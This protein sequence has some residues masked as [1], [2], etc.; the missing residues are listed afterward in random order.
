ME[1]EQKYSLAYLANSGSISQ[2]EIT[3]GSG[4]YMLSIWHKIQD[5]NNKKF[6]VI[7]H[8]YK[9]MIGRTVEFNFTAKKDKWEQFSSNIQV[10]Q[11]KNINKAVIVIR[12]PYSRNGEV[13]LDDI[14]LIK[15]ESG[16][17]TP[18]IQKPE[19]PQQVKAVAFQREITQYHG[20]RV[21]RKELHTK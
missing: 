1:M 4:N 10:P 7:F 18:E 6:Y 17:T 21:K 11:G 2:S 16:S 15:S 9:M 3:V 13:Y 8:F 14:S 20:K 5:D 12:F 19:K